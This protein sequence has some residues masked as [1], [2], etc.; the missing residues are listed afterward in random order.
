MK[1][2]Y[3]LPSTEVIKME[4]VSIVAASLNLDNETEVDTSTEGGQLG[5]EDRPSR[6]NL[7]DQTW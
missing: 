7:W 4:T 1:K 6:P 2:T 3:I 5:R